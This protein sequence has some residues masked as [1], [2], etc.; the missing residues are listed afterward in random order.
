MRFR[1][2]FEKEDK[3]IS[4]LPCSICG[5]AD[6]FI[7]LFQLFGIGYGICYLYLSLLLVA[8]EYLVKL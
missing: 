7:C 6:K 4:A 1:F 2:C 3:K 5:S 8:G